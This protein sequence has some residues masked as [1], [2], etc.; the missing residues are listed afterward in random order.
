MKILYYKILDFTPLYSLASNWLDLT[1]HWVKF[2][3]YRRQFEQNL[4]IIFI[5]MIFCIFAVCQ[6]H[7][8]SMIC[9]RCG[10]RC[11]CIHCK[12]RSSFWRYCCWF[13]VQQFSYRHLYITKKQFGLLI[14]FVYQIL[15]VRSRLILMRFV[16]IVIWHRT[17]FFGKAKTFISINICIYNQFRLIFKS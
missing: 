1:S 13:S 16:G 2:W 10:A 12:C 4:R 11:C 14:M 7:I 3:C 9:C 8:I 15:I 17:V 6:H 5:L